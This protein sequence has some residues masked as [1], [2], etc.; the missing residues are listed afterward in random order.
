MV[1]LLD[2]NVFIQAKNLHY[3]LDFCPAFWDWLIARNA[4]GQVFSIEKVG[5]ELEGGADELAAW[6]TQRGPSF[7]VR[8]DAAILPALGSVSAWAAGQQYD[9]AAVNTFLQLADYYLVAHALAYGQTVVTH[10]VASTSTKKIK[11]PDACIGLGIKCMT[12]FEMLRRER[13]RFVLEA[14]P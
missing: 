5:D 8:P 1:Y 7:F 2:A 10:E 11:I 14:R 12:P 9:P 3:G 4:A 6:A 13:A